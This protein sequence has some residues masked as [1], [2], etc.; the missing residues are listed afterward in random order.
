[1]LVLCGYLDVQHGEQILA[2]GGLQLFLGTAN[3]GPTPP[4]P[5]LQIIIP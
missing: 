1:M 3:T 5:N 2:F 4:S